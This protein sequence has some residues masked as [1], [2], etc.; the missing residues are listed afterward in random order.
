N[1]S[2]SDIK[3]KPL[4]LGEVSRLHRDGEGLTLTDTRVP[5]LN[6]LPAFSLAAKGAKKKLGK[7]KRR[8]AVSPLRR[9]GGLRALH[10]RELLKKLDQNF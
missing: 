8:Q 1:T 7:K 10:L 4:P 9:R 2:A 3:K 6:R 5:H